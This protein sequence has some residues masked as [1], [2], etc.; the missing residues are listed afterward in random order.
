MSVNCDTIILTRVY[1]IDTVGF[2]NPHRTCCTAGNRASG[3][4]VNMYANSVVGFYGSPRG[5]DSG[6]FDCWQC[7]WG[8][9]K[10]IRN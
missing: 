1:Y 7:S 8:G 6:L 9:E 2:R 3:C 4:P 10:T 5:G